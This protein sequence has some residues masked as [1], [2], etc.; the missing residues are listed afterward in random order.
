[1]KIES[2]FCSVLL[3]CDVSSASHASCPTGVLVATS[4]F[5]NVSEVGVLPLDGS[6]PTLIGSTALGADP[7]LVS[8]SG[9]HFFIERDREGN[10]Y[11]LDGCGQALTTYASHDPAETTMDPQDVAVAADGSLWVARLFASSAIAIGPTISKVDLSSTDADGVPNMS[12]VRIANGKAFI[13]LGLLDDGDPNLVARRPAQMAIV[14]VATRTLEAVAPIMGRNPIGSMPQIGVTLWIATMGDIDRADET[15]AGIVTFE[16]DTR[17]SSLVVPES[18]IGGS[19]SAIAI[20]DHCGAAIAFDATPNVNRTFLVAFDT[21][22]AIVQ[23]VA[24]GPTVGFDLAGLAWTSGELLVGDRRLVAGAFAAHT[25]TRDATC[26]L[27]RGAE[28]ALP[29][30]PVAFAP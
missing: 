28:L 14:D 12:A 9:R 27:T 29:M 1:M 16:T 23:R 20:D 10:I 26:K 8:S 24:F 4:D 13:A 5:S 11:E 21:S 17:A 18:Q 3:A 22:G 2:M 7:A 30:A 19:V 15:D 6:A 25:F